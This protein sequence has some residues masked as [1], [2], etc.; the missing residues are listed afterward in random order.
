MNRESSLDDGSDRV[1]DDDDEFLVMM[2]MIIDNIDYKDDYNCCEKGVEL[3]RR[4]GESGGATTIQKLAV[5]MLS[6]QVFF[7]ICPIPQFVQ[8]PIL[9]IIINMLAYIIIIIIHLFYFS[10]F[11]L[12]NTWQYFTS[13][14][15][16]QVRVL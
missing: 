14:F 15:K 16:M 12:D 10:I 9:I 11:Q 1:D 13:T 4:L 2:V 7:Y 8:P 3:G 5:Q 6:N